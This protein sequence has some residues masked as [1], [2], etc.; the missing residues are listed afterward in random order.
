MLYLEK[1]NRITESEAIGPYINIETGN[2][3]TLAIDICAYN[4]HN[5]V[6]TEVS[7]YIEDEY[8]EYLVYTSNKIGNKWE[9][10]EIPLSFSGNNFRYKINGKTASGGIFIDNIK[11][12]K[13]DT[14]NSTNI[15][16]N[17]ANDSKIYIYRL[18]GAF[19]GTYENFKTHLEPNLYLLRKGNRTWKINITR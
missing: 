12:Y 9:T 6:K 19:I 8:G 11:L 7:I 1:E 13:E 14:T 10:I 5:Q 17:N 15:V 2:N 16:N 3:Y 4:T 18:D